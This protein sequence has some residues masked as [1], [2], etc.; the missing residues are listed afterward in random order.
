[1]PALFEEAA[2]AKGDN[3]SELQTAEALLAEL[4]QTQPPNSPRVRI[5]ESYR[6]MAIND[7]KSKNDNCEAAVRILDEILHEDQD[8][9]AAI[10]GK[11]T[12]FPASCHDSSFF[13]ASFVAIATAYT[14]LKKAPQARNHLKRVSKLNYVP[15]YANEFEKCYLMLADA[16]IQVSSTSSIGYDLL[17]FSPFLLFLS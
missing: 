17:V 8:N 16:Y 12:S 6:L 3:S 9:V 10:L 4:K 14:L 1:M 13:F 11:P 15:E 7:E 2:E 5:L